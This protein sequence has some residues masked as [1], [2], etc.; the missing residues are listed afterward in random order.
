[1]QRDENSID[2]LV[3][4]NTRKDSIIAK[5]QEVNAE[6]IAKHQEEMAELL[7]EMDKL[8]ALTSSAPEPSVSAATHEKVR[9]YR[10]RSDPVSPEFVAYLTPSIQV[11]GI[12]DALDNDGNGMMDSGEAHPCCSRIKSCCRLVA[13]CCHSHKSSRV[14]VKVLIAKLT[15]KNVHEVA[16]SHPEVQA[17]VGKTKVLPNL[18]TYLA[19][20]QH[21]LAHRSRWWS[22]LSTP[23]TP[24]S[25]SSVMPTSA[26]SDR[27]CTA[28]R[29]PQRRVHGRARCAPARMRGSK[30]Y[31]MMMAMWRVRAAGA[32]EL[33]CGSGAAHKHL[34]VVHYPT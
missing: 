33:A 20:T 9:F 26:P 22:F 32:Y 4:E 7:R 6:M 28:C 19:L 17:L 23:P 8:R 18:D 24:T 21:D 5:H 10:D 1:L 29:P 34:R 15:N 16:D 11:L 12:V 14:Q 13:S 3:K 27:A 25:S 31:W 30:H 2:D